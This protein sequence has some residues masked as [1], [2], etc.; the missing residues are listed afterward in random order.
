[1]AQKD[2]MSYNYAPESEPVFRRQLRGRHGQVIGC[3]VRFSKLFFVITTIC[4]YQKTN[5]NCA[6]CYG[7]RGGM[8]HRKVIKSESDERPSIH[9]I[10]GH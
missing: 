4:A 3:H 1:V 9:W 2:R 5:L 6:P 10:H 8:Q 7:D